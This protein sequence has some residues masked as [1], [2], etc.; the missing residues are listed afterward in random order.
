MKTLTHI[1]S[2]NVNIYMQIV[3]IGIY[4]LSTIYRYILY[5]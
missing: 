5:I 1:R 4:K 3:N 2:S